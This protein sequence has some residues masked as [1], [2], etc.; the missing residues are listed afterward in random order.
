MNT[1]LAKNSIVG[2]KELRENIET[3]IQRVKDGE[4]LTIMRRNQP[5]FL[6]SPV[7]TELESDWETVIDFTEIKPNGVSA[8]ELLT[9]LRAHG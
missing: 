3:Y 9:S 7:E 2:L 5:I 6:L 4:S 1:K 8:K